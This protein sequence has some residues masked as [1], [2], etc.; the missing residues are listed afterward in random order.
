MV[1]F[2]AEKNPQSSKKQMPSLYNQDGIYSLPSNPIQ[3]HATQLWEILC[4]KDTA[5]AYQQA[6]TQTWALLI[7]FFWLLYFLI[8][9]LAAISIWFCGV[10]F[11][12]GWKFRQ[13]LE[14]EHPSIE[15]IFGLVLKVLLAPL[16]YA[17]KWSEWFVKKYFGWEFKTGHGEVP[18]ETEEPSEQIEGSAAA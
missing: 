2:T 7:Q 6:G 3:K 18:K 12:S 5:T 10:G 16:V 13:W 4:Q 9:A 1:E 14:V 17:F 11:H 8:T 15:E